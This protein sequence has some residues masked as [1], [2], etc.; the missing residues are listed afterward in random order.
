MLNII[1]IEPA[2]ARRRA[3]AA[4]AVAQEPKVRTCSATEFAVPA[5]LYASMPEDILIGSTVDGHRYVS[6]EL[7]APFTEPALEPAREPAP[8]P[9]SDD[10]SSI[11]DDTSTE[12]ASGGGSGGYACPHCPRE[13][14]TRRGRDTHTR[15]VHNE[16]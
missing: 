12:P 14:T 1:R 4:W 8:A 13:F 7:D 10:D 9:V 2:P 16:G 11:P 15:A 3:F 6:P 5:D